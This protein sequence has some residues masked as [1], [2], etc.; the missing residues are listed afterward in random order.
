MRN[1]NFNEICNNAIILSN[2]MRK[3]LNQEAKHMANARCKPA[4]WS[5]IACY[6]ESTY[7]IRPTEEEIQ[8][9]AYLYSWG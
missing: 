6:V 3:E 1:V 8:K 2:M 5:G 4:N 9:M 7:G